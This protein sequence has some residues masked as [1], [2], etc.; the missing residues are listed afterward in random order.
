MAQLFYVEI[1]N[2]INKK[3]YVHNDIHAIDKIE[4]EARILLQIW[5]VNIY[6]ILPHE[7]RLDPY[8]LKHILKS[9]SAL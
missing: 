6:S 2:I 4:L 5:I 8:Y 9:P 7:G 3:F 1:I